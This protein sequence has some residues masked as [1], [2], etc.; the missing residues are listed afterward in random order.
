MFTLLILLT[1]MIVQVIF[2]AREEGAIET[3]VL[4]L[5]QM[6]FNISGRCVAITQYAAY[7]ATTYEMW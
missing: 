4:D 2:D 5:E 3:K 1:A 7:T 6:N